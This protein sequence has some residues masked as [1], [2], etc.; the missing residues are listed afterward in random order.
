VG[1]V[2]LDGT[3]TNQQA[4]TEKI[5]F[6]LTENGTLGAAVVT[7]TATTDGSK[8]TDGTYTIPAACGFSAEHGTFTAY[9][10]SIAFG[11]DVYSGTLNGGADVIVA[12]FTSTA[13]SFDLALSGQDN[14]AQFAL[15]G[16][17]VGL[18][19]VSDQKPRRKCSRLVRIIRPNIQHV[20]DLRFRQ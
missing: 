16:S 6:T 19:L 2:T 10:Y 9:N 15:N 12:T 7:A 5:T 1:Q 18:F 4:T 17:T 20:S 8:I 11:S 13:N 14:G 3:L